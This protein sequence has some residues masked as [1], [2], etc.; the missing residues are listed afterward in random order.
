MIQDIVDEYNHLKRCETF[1]QE[2]MDLIWT[3][4]GFDNLPVELKTEYFALENKFDE[5]DNKVSD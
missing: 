3:H 5:E 4:P 2:V 1:L